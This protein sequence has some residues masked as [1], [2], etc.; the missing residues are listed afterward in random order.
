MH[1]QKAWQV[2]VENTKNMIEQTSNNDPLCPPTDRDCYLDFEQTSIMP[3]A[4]VQDNDSSRCYEND[5]DDATLNEN[6]SSYF[7]RIPPKIERNH[8][9]LYQQLYF[10][11]PSKDVMLIPSSTPYDEGDDV[12][13]LS[14][15]SISEWEAVSANAGAKIDL[16][17]T[18]NRFFPPSW[19]SVVNDAPSVCS[20]S[21][22]TPKRTTTF[23]AL[24]EPIDFE[25]CIFTFLDIF[26]KLCHRV[27]TCG[28]CRDVSYRDQV[29]YDCKEGNSSESMNMY[30]YLPTP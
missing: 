1:P 6:S 28:D 20:T 26:D 10:Y 11:H 27:A 3:P 19:D 30:M 21:W 4:L 14:S 9:Y 16:A 29:F 17:K 23:P 2:H 13:S 24:P 5:V 18:G 12:G 25:N 15:I 22:G 8:E 7:I